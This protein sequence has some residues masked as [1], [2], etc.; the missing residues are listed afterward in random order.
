MVHR[1]FAYKDVLPDD[2]RGDLRDYTLGA[3]PGVGLKFQYFPGAHFTAGV[4]AQFGIDFEWERLFKID[5]TRA[6][7]QTF[8][9]ESQQFLV[10]TSCYYITVS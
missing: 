5:S 3:G 10:A 7:G 6:D 2:P 8:P 4:G 9:T 1:D